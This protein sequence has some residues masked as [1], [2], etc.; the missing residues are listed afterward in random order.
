MARSFV[1]VLGKDDRRINLIVDDSFKEYRGR[2]PL[3]MLKQK[4]IDGL[5]SANALVELPEGDPNVSLF[6][7]RNYRIYMVEDNIVY[8]R[9]PI[10]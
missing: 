2:V 9:P 10:R 5:G 4:M 1:A 8:E 3:G 7:E 6:R